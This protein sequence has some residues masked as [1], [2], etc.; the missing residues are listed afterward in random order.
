MIAFG[1]S[2]LNELRDVIEKYDATLKIENNNMKFIVRS[3]NESLRANVHLDECSI[4][5][6]SFGSSIKNR[7]KI[8]RI[9]VGVDVRKKN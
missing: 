8:E 1:K 4:D 3:G 6:E 9:S 7:F 2:F 5:A